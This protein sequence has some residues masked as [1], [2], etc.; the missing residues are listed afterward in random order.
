MLST[1]LG[2]RSDLPDHADEAGFSQH[3]V[4]ELV[5]PGGGRQAGRADH[6]VTHARQAHVVD[7]AVGEIDPIRQ[8]F[9][10]LE[11]VGDALRGRRHATGRILPESKHGIAT[12]FQLAKVR[13]GDTASTL[14]RRTLPRLAGDLRPIR[15]AWAGSARP[16][17]AIELQK[18]T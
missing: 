9:A 2:P 13:P 8:P 6:F 16:G 5:H 3:R 7:G 14:T 11:H 12:L 15:P 4:G 17:R 18:C 1:V 10:V